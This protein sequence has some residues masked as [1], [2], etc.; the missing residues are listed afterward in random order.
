MLLSY[1]DK[2]GQEV[3]MERLFGKLFPEEAFEEQKLHNLFS[4]LKK[5]YLRFLALEELFHSGK[6]SKGQKI[7]MI[8]PES[9][10]FTYANVLL[11]VC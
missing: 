10:R 1:L 3:D 4:G 2:S 6:L 11:T 8:I 5:L 7:A 9:A